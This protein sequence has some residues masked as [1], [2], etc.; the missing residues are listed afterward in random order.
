ME[1]VKWSSDEDG[2]IRVLGSRWLCKLEQN[3]N[4]TTDVVVVFA[5][6]EVGWIW[7]SAYSCSPFLLLVARRV[8][9]LLWG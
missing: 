9:N 3:K 5:A 7:F 1:Q 2:K 8:M 4:D 6:N